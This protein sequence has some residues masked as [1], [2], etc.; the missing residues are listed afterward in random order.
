MPLGLPLGAGLV[1]GY[2]IYIYIYIY[3]Q[4]HADGPRD[5]GSFNQSLEAFKAQGALAV[6]ARLQ[7]ATAPSC[8]LRPAV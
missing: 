7:T 4:I 6:I 8:P 5:V 2:Y 1:N 3:R